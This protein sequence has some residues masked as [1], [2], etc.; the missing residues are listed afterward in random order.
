L[1]GLIISEDEY[2]VTDMALATDFYELTMAAAY[3]YSNNYNDRH[4]ATKKLLFLNC[5]SESFQPIE[6]I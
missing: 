3:Y 5:L 1:E 6:L 2:H 4:F